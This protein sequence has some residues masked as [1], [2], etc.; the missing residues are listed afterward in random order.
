MT[1]RYQFL[2]AQWVAAA[3]AIR[4]EYHDRLAAAAGATPPS[5]VRMNQ[6]VTDG[7]DGTILAHLDTT[8][9]QAR[10]ELG[11]LAEADVT[12]TTDYETAR[13]IWVQQDPAA[14]MTAFMAGKIRVE[15]DLARLLA[16]QARAMTPDPL[17]EEIT[18]RVRAITAD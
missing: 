18:S 13:S 6:T 5:A 3:R 17:A 1:E 2:S 15:G 12:I 4:D 9:G 7:P 11:H 8:S 10:L 14:A 16:M